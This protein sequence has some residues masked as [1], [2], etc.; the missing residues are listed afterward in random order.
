MT[1]KE[2][3]NF[4]K[5]LL[6]PT[7]D[8]AIEDMRMSKLLF[9]TQ[10]NK[11]YSYVVDEYMRDKEKYLP[12]I[13]PY[14]REEFIMRYYRIFQKVND[15]DD[16]EIAFKLQDWEHAGNIMMLLNDNTDWSSVNMYLEG[17]QDYSKEAMNGLASKIYHFS[18]DGLK[19]VEHISE[20]DEE[21]KK[22]VFTKYY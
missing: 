13:L 14:M 17:L 10:N 8:N 15:L 21:F 11:F 12:F 1:K 6:E 9:L 22:I 7:I 16:S 2:Q 3:E 5:K 19:F 20:N 18:P 4:I